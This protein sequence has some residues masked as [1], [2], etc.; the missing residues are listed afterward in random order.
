M[1]IASKMEEIYAPKLID[2]IK[3]ADSGYDIQEVK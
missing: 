3:A 2:F 1:Y